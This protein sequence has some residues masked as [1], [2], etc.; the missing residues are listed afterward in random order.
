MKPTDGEMR[1]MRYIEWGLGVYHLAVTARER[2]TRGRIIRR[3]F[4]RGWLEST[5]PARLTDEG[6]AVFIRHG[7]TPG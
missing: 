3:L 5:N 4:V 6:R 7:G 1:V 2:G